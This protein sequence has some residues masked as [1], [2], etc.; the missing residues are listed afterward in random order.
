MPRARIGT[1]VLCGLIVLAVVPGLVALV[2]DHGDPQVAYLAVVLPCLTVPLVAALVVSAHA[3]GNV[4][5]TLLATQSLVIALV[6]STDVYGAVASRGEV[7]HARVARRAEGRLLDGRV[8]RV[9]A[10]HPLLP[11]RSATRG[12]MAG[13]SPWRSPWSFALFE[14]GHGTRRTPTSH[15]GRTS[16]TRTST[17][18]WIVAMAMVPAFLALMVAS[19]ASLVR[20]YRRAGPG[21]RHQIRWLV[22]ASLLVPPT[23]ALSWL[24]EAIV[25]ETDL[26]LVALLVLLAAMYV[27]VPVAVAIA[28]I[29]DDLYEVDRA[30]VA[31]SVYGFVGVVLLAVFTAV[32]S[33]AG[34]RRGPAST[35]VAVLVTAVV[36]V[37]LGTVRSRL[38]GAVGDRI[39]P[40][41]ARATAA[42]AT[43]QHEVSAGRPCP[44][45]SNPVLRTAL[46]DPM[47][48]VGYAVP[49]DTHFVD[50]D[51]HRVDADHGSVPVELAGHRVGVLV[52][53]DGV[54][55]WLLEEVAG[56]AAL[57]VETGRLRLELSSALREVE[58]SR[59]RLVQAGYE[60]RRRL[61]LDLHDGAQQRLVSLGMSLRLAQRHLGDGDGRRRRP[62]RRH[63]CRARHG[64]GRAPTDR[65]RTTPQ[66]PRRRAGSGAGEPQPEHPTPRGPGPAGGG[67]ARPHQHHG[68]L[69]RLRGGR[70]RR[71]A[72]RCRCHRAVGAPRRGSRAG[73]R[74]R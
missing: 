45:S 66:Q 57:L 59:S 18:L 19:V 38:V 5:G 52:A 22:L 7:P 15:R 61:E 46:R 20:R 73:Q 8:H 32:S 47:L 2:V 12:A 48:R 44:S 16:R 41:R 31:A 53:G 60:E 30:V 10:A 1:L 54:R 70:E 62:A 50:R 14:R 40:D 33:A 4:V 17:V 58:A 37:F 43:L 72:R 71:Q 49:G 25:G 69:R 65:P 63:G 51:G 39:Y 3:P 68:L 35:Q 36:A 29:R 28:V 34:L 11:G 74:Q 9:R 6:A 56:E 26:Q 23:L 42:V 64:R 21:Q 55:P 67:P 24:A 13:W 27:V